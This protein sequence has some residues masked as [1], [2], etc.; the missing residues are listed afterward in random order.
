LQSNYAV[1]GEVLAQFFADNV[2]LLRELV[3]D[4]VRRMYE[5]YKAPNDERYWMAGVGS[6]V[7]A[8]IIFGDKY[9][10][11]ANIPV[12]EIIEAYRKQIDHLR[13]C[14]KG[15]KR[16][17]EDVLNAYIQEYQG[18]FVI[19]KFG[20]KAGPAAMFGDGTS[21]GKTTT[22]QEVMGRVEHGVSPGCIDFYIEERLL[23]AFCSN[24]SFSYTT[25]K[26][27]IAHVFS[28]YQAPKKDMLAKTDGPPLRV[29]AL[30]LTANANTLDDAT[31]LPVSMG[32]A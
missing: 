1:A 9:T 8:C 15:G 29:M 7:A 22:R 4:C 19:V 12:Q 27:E 17:A 21:V 28:V 6:V 26:T 25:F 13:S 14:I 31:I 18:K 16:T 23:R 20:E 32:T 10:G 5:E 24:M 30:K 2:P 3:P 11:L